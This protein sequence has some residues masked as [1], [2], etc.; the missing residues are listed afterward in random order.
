VFGHWLI[1]RA[2]VVSAIQFLAP[3]FSLRSPLPDFVPSSG[4]N[5]FT[6]WD[7]RFYRQIAEA[8]YEYIPDGQYHSVAFFP[9]F[10]LL[11][12]AAMAP[13]LSFAV[14]GTLVNSVAL[15]AAMWHL[16]NWMS[17]RYGV[18]EAKWAV[19]VMAWFP[20][21]LFA[22]VT[23]SEG[24]FLLTTTA[25]LVAFDRGQYAR[26][27]AWGAMASA[28]RVPGSLLVPALLI[29]S[30]HEKRP[31]LAYFAALTSVTGLAT[32]MLYCT[33]HFG[34]PFAFLHAQAGW[35]QDAIYWTDAVRTI[36]RKRGLALDSLVR[37]GVYAG[38][39]AVFWIARSRLSTA[40]L[41]YGWFSLLLLLLVNVQSIGRFV[42]GIATFPVALGIV[43]SSHRRIAWCFLAVCALTLLLFSIRWAWWFWVA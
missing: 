4:W 23:Y 14:A 9:L 20:Y 21:S 19:A 40:M 26:T 8:G 5:L 11:T 15:L 13:G 38:A 30:Q 2:V 17:Q 43:L 1:S 35:A 41:L 3:L 32:F 33:A 37:L 12:K 6:H 27:G 28:S 29:A 25:A 7:G 34:D 22:T 36:G 24:V 18:E 39:A 42:Y 31:K 16:Y 10:P